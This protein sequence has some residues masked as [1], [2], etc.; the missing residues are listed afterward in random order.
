M[1]VKTPRTTVMKTL[2]ASV[3]ENSVPRFLDIYISVCMITATPQLYA[4]IYEEA[5]FVL[6]ENQ[7]SVSV[8]LALYTYMIQSIIQSKLPH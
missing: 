7:Y 3:S 1:S 2:S 5:K 6:K 4:L 8:L